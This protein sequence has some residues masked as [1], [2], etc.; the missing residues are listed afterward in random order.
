MCL[1]EVFGPKR[2]QYNE[3]C[4]SVKVIPGIIRAADSTVNRIRHSLQP[5]RP[6]VRV[7]YVVVN[8]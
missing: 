3:S 1:K 4:L 8:I 5:K 2:S 7:R 6:V